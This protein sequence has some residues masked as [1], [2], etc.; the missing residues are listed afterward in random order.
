MSSLITFKKRENPQRAPV[1]F[2]LPL[3]KI[4]QN[5]CA[6]WKKKDAWFFAAKIQLFFSEPRSQLWAELCMFYCADSSAAASD[7]LVYTAALPVSKAHCAS[8]STAKLISH[9]RSVKLIPHRLKPTKSVNNK[10]EKKNS[11]ISTANKK[12]AILFTRRNSNS[13]LTATACAVC[14][15]DLWRPPAITRPRL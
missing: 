8:Q 3:E 12:S 15:A 11:F 5:P 4:N 13:P 9:T 6:S 14:N 10:K 2:F 1:F 7:S